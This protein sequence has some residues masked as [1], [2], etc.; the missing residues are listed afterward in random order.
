MVAVRALTYTRLYGNFT[1][2]ETH[3]IPLVEMMLDSSVARSFMFEAIRVALDGVAAGRG[4][5]FGA[6]VVKDGQIVGRGCNEVT[7]RNDPTAHAEMMAIRETGQALGMFHLTGCELYTTCEPCPMCLS[8]IYWA[9][10]DRYYFGCTTHDAAAIEFADSFIH[11][12][13]GLPPERRSIPAVGLMR[14]EALTVF[15]AWQ[16]KANRV[17]Y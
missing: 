16:A 4:G 8:A 5:P 12:E 10:I 13:L 15:A 7:S 1:F 6:V 17:A 11:K 3:S 14:D 2:T 9:K